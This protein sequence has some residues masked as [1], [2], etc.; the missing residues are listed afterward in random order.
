VS[1]STWGNETLLKIIKE[2]TKTGTT[3]IGGWD[4]VVSIVTTYM[5]AVQSLKTDGGKTNPKDHPAFYTVGTSPLPGV[6]WPGH[7][8]DHSLRSSAKVMNIC[9]IICSLH[10]VL[11]WHVIMWNCYS[12]TTIISKCWYEY[13]W[14][15]KDF[16]M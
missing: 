1:K 13:G 12:F 16:I 8:I 11:S 15:V 5:L 14:K 2:Y 6:K 4:S 3:I 7:G 9:T 10:S